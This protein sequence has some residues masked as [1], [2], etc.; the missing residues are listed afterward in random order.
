MIKKLYHHQSEKI[1]TEANHACIGIR[2]FNSYFTES[3]IK[4]LIYWGNENF[5]FF[6]IFIPDRPTV[7]ALN[8]MGYS[9]EKSISRTEKQYKYVKNK[10]RKALL[11]LGKNQQEIDA[12]ILDGSKLEKNTNFQTTYEEVVWHFENDI[13]FRLHCLEASKWVLQE[14]IR[15]IDLTEEMLYIAVKYFLYEIPVFINAAN[16]VGQDSSL[17]CYHQ[18]PSFL[19]K[20]YEYQFKLKPQ[21]NQGFAELNKIDLS[22]TYTYQYLKYNP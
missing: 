18:I 21:D 17:F 12:I 9:M 16:I 5:T 20:I 1:Y 3:I 7:Y 2:L 4:K 13:S 10:V 14:K 6:N 19:Q 8:A 22:C 11:S 15:E